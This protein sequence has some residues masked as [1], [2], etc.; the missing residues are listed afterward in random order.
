M[1]K[2]EITPAVLHQIAAL[3]C[4]GGAEPRLESYGAGHI[5]Q[6]WLVTDESGRRYI[7]QRISEELTRDAAGLTDNII[8][9][10]RHLRSRETDPDPRR[11]L[12][13]VPCRDGGF[14]VQN[15]YG[16]WRAFDFIEDSVCLQ[17]VER[18]ED[19]Y[20]SALAFGHFEELLKDFDV[21]S[22]KETIVD[23]HNTPMRCRR[24]HEAIQADAAG[25]VREVEREIGFLLEREE[26][27]GLLQQLREKGELPVRVTHNDTKLNNV[28]L[29]KS[30]RKA[31]CVIDLDTV[32]PG[33]SLYDFG[34]AIRYG[35]AT[36]DEDERDLSRQ[37]LD[38]QR[39]RIFREGFLKACPDLT[40]LERELLATG[41]RVI[42]LEQAV[43][44]LTDYLEGDIYYHT[45]RPGQNLDR[46]RTQIRLAQE[47][48][49]K[50]DLLMG[51]DPT[52]C[53]YTC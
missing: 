27:M 15:E 8:K 43:R 40:A 3:F 48:E 42:T 14:L 11:V 5:N 39:Y 36:A 16:N 47:M 20:Q 23:F 29:D 41:A 49:R 38:L 51:P 21:S 44:F 30:T 33:L 32:M 28:L 34:D 6:T 18:E 50:W 45:T 22:L 19:F 53:R 1:G 7:L 2:K 37:T 12:T 24:F 46:C 17:T 25:R 35:A 10:T 9:I 13:P 4:A 52:T 26:E 31:L